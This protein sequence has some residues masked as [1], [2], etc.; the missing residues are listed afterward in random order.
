M[1]LLAIAQQW[2]RSHETKAPSEKSEK[3]EIRG[4]VT[5]LAYLERDGTATQLRAIA[6]TLTP[7]EHQRLRAEAAAGDRLAAL[8]VGVLAVPVTTEGR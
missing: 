2:E 8:M 6:A 3:S 5:V 7:E 4:D 1:N